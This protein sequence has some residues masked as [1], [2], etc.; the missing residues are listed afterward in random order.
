MQRRL[1]EHGPQLVHWVA[2]VDRPKSLVRWREQYPG[3]IPPV[4]A[5]SRGGNTWGLTVPDD[6]AFPAWRDAGHGVLPSLIQWDTP[7]HPGDALPV[8]GIL[9]RSLTGFH[10]NADAVAEQLAWLGASHLMRVEPTAGAPVIVAEFELPDGSTLTLGE[11]AE[12]AEAARAAQQEAGKR[13]RAKGSKTADAPAEPE[14]PFST[15]TTD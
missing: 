15:D 12:T 13:R 6:G 11:A 8:S 7:R 10:P 5:M 4:A 9:L 14:L 1:E 2:R 3:R